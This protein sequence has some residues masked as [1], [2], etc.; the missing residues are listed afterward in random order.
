MLYKT[1]VSIGRS[2]ELMTEHDMNMS[3]VQNV[4]LAAVKIFGHASR[5]SSQDLI[6]KKFAILCYCIH[7]GML[8][9]RG[10]QLDVVGEDIRKR[11]VMVRAYLSHPHAAYTSQCNFVVKN[12][13]VEQWS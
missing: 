5:V 4:M 9:H 13:Q 3:I 6:K 7:I 1:L 10:Y 12:A 2:Q 8:G 11:Y